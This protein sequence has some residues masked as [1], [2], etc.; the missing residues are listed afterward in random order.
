M[1]RGDVEQV[2]GTDHG[3]LRGDRHWV[4]DPNIGPKPGCWGSTWF[5]DDIVIQVWYGEEDALV[6][7]KEYR[8]LVPP[9]GR[10]VL[11]ILR[12]WLHL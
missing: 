2:L 6:S 5:G 11:Q 12:E 3:R 10:S 4:G 8:K 9:P 7:D 1:T